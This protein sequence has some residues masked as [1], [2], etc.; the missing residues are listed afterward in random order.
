MTVA[1]LCSRFTAS[2]VQCMAGEGGLPCLQI[3]TDL[4]EATIYLHGAHVTHFQPRGHKPV[5]FMSRSSWFA[6]EKPIRGG[7]PICFPWF[8]PRTD[9]QDGP[10]HGFA[11]LREWE[12]TQISIAGD[13]AVDVLLRL[14]PTDL[15]RSLWP[16]DFSLEYRVRVAHDLRMTLSVTNLASEPM[17]IQEA[18]HTYIAIG[19]IHRTSLT[20][21]DGVT[22]L[23]KMDGAKRKIEG[24]SPITF[25]A[26]TDR[27]YLDTQSTCVI[28]DPT[29][30]RKITIAKTGSN[31]TVVWNPWIAKSKAMADFGD[32]EWPGMLCVET[33]NAAD[34]TLTLAPGASHAIESRISVD[35][36]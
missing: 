20:G 5:L 12:V 8:G 30:G 4:A 31:A 19:D 10:A 32:E 13:G 26:E 21:L 27:V 15:T 3:K 33:A 6:G 1:D 9:G 35:A 2:P 34:N 7:V 11:R 25:T 28:H 36:L 14:P 16:A 24:P 18:L 23:D 17:T 22:Y 29:L